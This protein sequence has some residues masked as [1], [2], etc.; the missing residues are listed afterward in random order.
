MCIASLFKSDEGKVV[1]TFTRDERNDRLFSPPKW[2]DDKVLAP[3]DLEAG[4]TWIGYNRRYILSLQNGGT[5]KHSR[6]LPY[7]MSRGKL[8]LDLLET[9]DWALF[10]LTLKNNK[11][12]PF[13]LTRIDIGSFDLTLYIYEDNQLNIQ[14]I[15][16]SQKFINCSSTLYND[17]FKQ[18]IRHEFE[19]LKVISETDIWAFHKSHAIGSEKNPLL[20]PASTSISQFV[21][22]EDNVWHFEDLNTSYSVDI[23]I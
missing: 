12:E 16:R 20:R 3:M 11:I 22:S 13:T 7:D 5:R 1:F 15:E 10:E 19:Q 23:Q 17:E 21:F 6:D 2:M 9:D 4:G 18:G 8:V 14:K